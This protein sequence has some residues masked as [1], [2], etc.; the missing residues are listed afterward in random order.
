MSP[1][2]PTHSPPDSLAQGSSVTRPVDPLS[3]PVVRRPSPS[4]TL[5]L[6]GTSSDASRYHFR[7]S[8]AV[9]VRV[10]SPWL[11]VTHENLVKRV[12]VCIRFR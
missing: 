8:K 4:S 3:R 11:P 5:P 12:S 6:R 7:Y 1:P 10:R 9:L 2:G